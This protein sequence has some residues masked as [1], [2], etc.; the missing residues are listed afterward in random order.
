MNLL[1]ENILADQR[2]VL[3]NWH[4][5]FRQ[6]GYDIARKGI[7]DDNIIPF[8]FALRQPTFFT[9][10]GDFYKRGFCH[11]RY[12]LVHLDVDESD[13]AVYI[14]RVLRH[15]EFST[16]AKR[17]G[18]VIRA[19]YSGLSVWRLHAKQELRYKWK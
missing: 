10:D 7:K 5:P 13:T 18:V 1:D 11:T 8:L 16:H 12:C 2:Q 6:I 17:M 14:R 9:S 3:L 4:V 19:S 15:P